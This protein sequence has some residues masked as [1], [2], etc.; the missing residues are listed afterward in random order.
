[1]LDKVS[2]KR[3]YNKII[4]NGRI[5]TKELREIGLTDEDVRNLLSISRKSLHV[6]R[7]Y[8][9]NMLL[10]YYKQEIE[11]YAN[12][13]FKMQTLLRVLEIDPKNTEAAYLIIEIK[14][15]NHDYADIFDYI[16]I[17]GGKNSLKE[18][19]NLLL[20]LFSFITP[21]PEKYKDKVANMKLEDVL[22]SGNTSEITRR[23]I[24]CRSVFSQ[25]YRTAYKVLHDT[26]DKSALDKTLE[27]I[28]HE[29]L[30]VKRDTARKIMLALEKYN[31][32][33]GVKRILTEQS[34]KRRLFLAEEMYLKICNAYFDID[35]GK[36]SLNPN[37]GNSGFYNAIYT[38]DYQTAL[39][40]NR[41]YTEENGKRSRI[42]AIYEMLLTGVL[43][44]V[45]RSYNTIFEDFANK[46]GEKAAED[47]EKYLTMSG[48]GQYKD[49][50][51]NLIKLSILNG[52]AY[53]V[54]PAVALGKI[55][56]GDKVIDASSYIP[57]YYFA[58]S[59]GDLEKAKV[60]MD[61]VFSIEKLGGPVADREFFRQTFEE[62]EKSQQRRKELSMQ[63]GLDENRSEKAE[64][65]TLPDNGDKEKVKEPV[66]VSDDDKKDDGS[67]EEVEESSSVT[68]KEDDDE[69]FA[70]LSDVVTYVK[71]NKSFR[72]LEKLD[73]TERKQ[74]IKIL[75]QIPNINV[76]LVEDRVAIRYVSLPEDKK[77]FYENLQSNISKA[78]KFYTNGYYDAAIEIYSDLCSKI[79]RP[80]PHIY[81]SLGLCYR[82]RGRS[83]EDY[84]RAR[85]SFI[86]AKDQG[87]YTDSQIAD[88]ESKLNGYDGAKVKKHTQK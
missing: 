50:M 2:I 52:D 43:G 36:F 33:D 45:K 1:M 49:Y 51:S 68:D 14:A 16:D 7:F 48:L 71:E 60:Y 74:V 47:V 76:S 57:E 64:K 70:L 46:D 62:E 31:D 75:S 19:A 41:S 18:S 10:G 25:H 58:I 26:D 22:V 35:N 73:P 54:E 82:R 80:K 24:L 37:G 79:E 4:F 59:V 56:K 39:K 11:P 83:K 6:Y 84:I 29:A 72:V 12:D 8:N 5:T 87:W 28:L 9:E 77:V 15:R 17:I 3:V 63:L 78:D 32:F 61:L 53:F 88:C 27:V 21:V 86:M 38:N 34:Q 66:V 81:G 23:N 40:L 20:Y 13:E 30:T 55:T 69:K 67:K 42:E 65:E 85:D 44:K